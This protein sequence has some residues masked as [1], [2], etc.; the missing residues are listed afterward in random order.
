M[1][2]GFKVSEELPSFLSFCNTRAS[3]FVAHTT[4]SLSLSARAHYDDRQTNAP[5][6]FKTLPLVFGRERVREKNV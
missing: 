2:L 6:S 3:L 1:A 5:S 4:L